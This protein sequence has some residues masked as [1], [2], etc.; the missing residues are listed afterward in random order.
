MESRDEADDI[1]EFTFFTSKEEVSTVYSFDRFI[2]WDLDDFERV[3][4]IKFFF[5]GLRSSCHT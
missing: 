5:L 2:G 1:V 3:Y 4:L